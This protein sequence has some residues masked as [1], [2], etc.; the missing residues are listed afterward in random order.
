MDKNRGRSMHGHQHLRRPDVL[1]FYLRRALAETRLDLETFVEDLAVAY[2]DDVPEH[3]R[4]LK[5]EVPVR[6]G[7]RDYARQVGRLVKRVQRY[8][9]GTLHFPCEIEEAWV[10]ALPASYAQACRVE[11]TRRHGF[12][13]VLAPEAAPCND[14]EAV[15]AVMS[16]TGQC[17][18]VL[19][20][21]LADGALTT[22]DLDA[23]PELLR[24]ILDAEATLAA[25]RARVQEVAAVAAAEPRGIRPRWAG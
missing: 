12:L 17:L 9:E 3:A 25:V 23:H 15:A 18:S 5:L 20:A 2:C 13:G 16:Q 1:R 10:A 7:Y 22:A 14:G 19:A 6:E 11:L 4:G 21:A 8:L 24:S